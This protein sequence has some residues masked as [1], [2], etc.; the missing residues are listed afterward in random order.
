[1]ESDLYNIK[2]LM[3]K[4]SVTFYHLR[5]KPQIKPLFSRGVVLQFIT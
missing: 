5:E 4:D 2:W 3:V 1:M